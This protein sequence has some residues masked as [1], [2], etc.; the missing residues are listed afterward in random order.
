MSVTIA[1]VE[2]GLRRL[3][4]EQAGAGQGAAGQGR[5][6][7]EAEPKVAMTG[8]CLVQLIDRRTGAG[9]RMNGRVVMTYSS[10]PDEAVAELMAG[11]DPAVWEA[12]VTRMTG[13]RV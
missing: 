13:G 1:K 12:R 11:R 4:L 8:L 10:D 9:H 6:A 3:R 2:P 7:F 5:S